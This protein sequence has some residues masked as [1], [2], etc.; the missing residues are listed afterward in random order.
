MKGIIMKLNVGLATYQF[1]GFLITF[2]AICIYANE[3]GRMAIFYI[4]LAI[5]L[6]VPFVIVSVFSF[7][8]RRKHL[9]KIKYA[10]Y[11]AT[12]LIVVFPIF[13]PLFYDKEFIYI[14]LVGLLIAFLLFFLRKDEEKQL[15]ILNLVGS[16][17]LSVIL[18]VWITG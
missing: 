17:F 18:F 8:D 11:L 15:L 14:S 9:N 3:Q 4:Y 5:A 10:V 12:L 13:L 1:I 7:L 2:L 6:F 16:V